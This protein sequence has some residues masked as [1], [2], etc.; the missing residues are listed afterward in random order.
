MSASNKN[1]LNAGSGML[2][3]V[4][5]GLRSLV[6]SKPKDDS[7]KVPDAPKAQ[8]PKTDETQDPKAATPAPE[9]RNSGTPDT[10]RFARQWG[11]MRGV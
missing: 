10:A 3:T 8:E 1:G 4:I 7:P 11:R 9:T 5:R 2:D 6:G